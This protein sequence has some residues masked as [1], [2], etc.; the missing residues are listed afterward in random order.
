MKSYN[1]KKKNKEMSDFVVNIDKIYQMEV[2]VDS[3][4]RIQEMLRGQFK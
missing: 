2:K 1:A 4:L 3:S